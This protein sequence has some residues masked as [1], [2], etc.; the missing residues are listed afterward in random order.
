MTITTHPIL[1]GICG[2]PVGPDNTGLGIFQANTIYM[3][4]NT[5][6]HCTD[7]VKEFIEALRAAKK[8]EHVQ[9]INNRR[10]VDG[11]SE[12][13]I[14]YSMVQVTPATDSLKI[15]EDL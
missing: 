12:D 4:R 10:Q 13:A 1:C 9:E 8:S 5:C 6:Q 15:D 11:H 14:A 3:I 7:S 2:V